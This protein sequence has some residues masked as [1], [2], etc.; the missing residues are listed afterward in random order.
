MDRTEAYKIAQDELVRVEQ[1]GFESALSNLGAS[2][3]EDIS[4]PSG[5]LYNVELIFQEHNDRKR[6]VKVTCSVTSKNWFRHE[7]LSESVILCE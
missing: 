3:Q 4:G 7:Q 6:R 2:L 5:D 1:E